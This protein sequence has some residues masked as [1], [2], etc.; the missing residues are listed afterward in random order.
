[1]GSAVCCLPT[2]IIRQITSLY[3]PYGIWI[4]NED[5]DNAAYL[6]ANNGGANHGWYKLQPEL[7]ESTI[8]KGQGILQEKAYGKY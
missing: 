2:V 8:R 7:P 3:P 5:M 4:I 6:I 1:M